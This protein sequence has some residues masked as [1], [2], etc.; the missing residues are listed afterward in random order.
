MKQLSGIVQ[1]IVLPLKKAV[2]AYRNMV[3]KNGVPP[4]A[5]RVVTTYKTSFQAQ[6]PLCLLALIFC[7]FHIFA[8]SDGRKNT[9]YVTVTNPLLFGGKAII[10]GYE[11][12][13]SK[14]QSFTFNIGRMSLPPFG[15]RLVSDS[16][17]LGNNSTEKGFHISGD[18]RF[19]LSKENKYEAPRGV[20]I[21]PY[22][23]YNSFSRTNEWELNST[24]FEGNVGT[25]TSLSFHTIGAELGYQFIFWKR[26]A[27]D[28]VLIGP[29]MAF[30]NLNTKLNT[31]LSPDD[32]SLFFEE[33]NNYLEEK[34]PGY[35]I[36]FDEGEFQANGSTKTT[37][38]GFR[39]MIN[40]G[41]R[42]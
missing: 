6:K 31:T 8:Q 37:S 5:A 24:N 10:V 35:N 22:Y 23:S 30:Y 32:E 12:L 1:A 15:S 42:F 16:L 27:V 28:L 26:L 29:G 40:V 14:N 25:N 38:F 7:T 19:Y 33:L 3:I 9:V 20:Y 2:F 4:V 41:F 39:Y 36:V 17:T 21:G 13:L 34:I 11:R 18:Y